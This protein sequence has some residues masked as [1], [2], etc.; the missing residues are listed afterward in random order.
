MLW[1][2]EHFVLI[3]NIKDKEIL[4]LGSNDMLVNSF[5]NSPSVLAI[6]SHLFIKVKFV[7]RV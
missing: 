2:P 4:K 7:T 5:L 1:K 6:Y 3:Y